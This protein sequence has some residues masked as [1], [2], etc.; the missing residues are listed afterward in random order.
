MPEK[1]MT[2]ADKAEEQ[3][4]EAKSPS[5]LDGPAW[6]NYVDRSES[7]VEKQ[8]CNSSPSLQN[9]DESV[10]RKTLFPVETSAPLER[11]HNKNLSYLTTHE[12]SR[13]P[14]PSWRRQS[15]ERREG[16]PASNRP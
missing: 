14:P 15:D 9:A 16:E 3:T 8:V 10:A 12:R 2:C 7:A 5:S 11:R 6:N 1:T 4:P 13:A